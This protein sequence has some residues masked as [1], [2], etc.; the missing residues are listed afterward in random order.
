MRIGPIKLQRVVRRL[1]RA[2]LFT[3]VAVATLALGIGA[4][5]AIFSVVR[6]VLLKPLPFEDPD[7]LVGVWHTAHG[8][9]ISVVNMSPAF[10]FTY[11][12]EGRAF[13]DIG[14]WNE[15]SVSV[16]GVG[17]PERVQALQVTDGTLPLLRVPALLG[18][19][20]TADDDSRR[21][22][23]RVM[24]MHGYWQRKFAG[25]PD[26]VG[27]LV[28]IEG[29]P[30]E[31]IGVLPPEFSFLDTNPQVVMPFR[32]DRAKVFIGNFS[33]Q[34]IARLQPGVT[35]EQAND[36]VARMIPIA[37]ERFPMPPGFTKE[38]TRDISFGPSVRALS[39]DA[40][41]DVGRVLWVVFAT[42]A[43]VLLIACANVANLFLVRAETRQH[44]LS[45]HAALGANWQRVAWEVMSESLLLGLVG[46]AVG[47]ALA[48]FGVKALVATAPEGLPRLGEIAIDPAVLLFTLVVSLVAGLLFGLIP[49]LKFASP[50]LASVLKQAGRGAS[51]GRERHR[52]RNA[53]VVVE[54]ALAV[55]LLV[56]SGLMI[57]TF[58]ALRHVEPGFTNPAQVLT[59]RVSIPPSLVAD[60]EQAARTH[61]AI[62]HSIERIPGVASV[63]VSSSITMDGTASKDPVYVEDFP[64]PGQR[65]PPLLHFKWIGENYFETMGNRLIAGRAIAW[66]DIYTQAAVVVVTEN[67]ARQYWTEPAASIG[68]RIRSSPKDTW[69]TIVGVVGDERDDGAAQPAPVT[70]YWPLLV[71]NFRNEPVYVHRAIAY[72]IRTDRVTSPT[73]LKEIQQAVWSVNGS[74]PVANVRT[75]SQI[76]ARSI[77]Q[78]SFALA[79]LA[80]AAGVA[81]LLG[82]V[83]IYGVIAY[84]ATQRTREIGIRMALGA[85]RRDVSGLFLKHG[86]RL[87][88]TGIGIGLIVAAVATRAMSALLFGVGA[89]DPLTY[90]AVAAGLGATALLASYLPAQRACRVDPA[91][92]L[93]ADA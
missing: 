3:S 72:V 88:A 37:M 17:E 9:N 14:G 79:M 36:E 91:E 24:L 11:R 44:E 40:V 32:F 87:A 83:G 54:I 85:A 71:K 33:F 80:I 31:I 57:R 86:L 16:T 64:L 35:I 75:L 13:E 12:E 26:V 15:T 82:V 4:N 68:R 7:R 52:A 22:P 2:P 56:A 30:R 74:V 50:H 39:Q 53:L 63:G 48:A 76:Q 45:I 81:L 55:V 21:T 28:T 10:Y 41:G 5:T 1:V 47:L 61:E 73:L 65:V 46:G 93:R 90:V 19:R 69:R 29:R 42:V 18:R 84:M 27:R 6:G 49:V 34:G 59:L 20:F 62:M 92:A 25:D 77:A 89:L 38:T 23:E 8:L 66:N 67:F 43:I 78:T 58:Q 70:I 51:A 60:A